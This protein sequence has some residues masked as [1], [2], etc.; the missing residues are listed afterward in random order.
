[1]MFSDTPTVHQRTPSPSVE[2]D[3]DARDRLRAAVEDT[4]LEVGEHEVGDLFLVFAEIL[5]QRQ[6]ERVDRPVAFRHRHDGMAVD[7][8]FHHRFRDRS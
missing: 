3:Q 1:M 7:D 8:Q 2:F 4:H 5:A 6:I